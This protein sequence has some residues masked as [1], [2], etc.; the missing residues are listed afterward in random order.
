MKVIRNDSGLYLSFSNRDSINIKEAD[1]WSLYQIIGNS[2]ISKK[3]DLLNDFYF[4]LE[5]RQI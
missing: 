2:E 3:N 5:K 4:W 1:L